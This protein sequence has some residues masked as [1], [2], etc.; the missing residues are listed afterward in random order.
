MG[1]GAYVYLP[2]SSL[3]PLA[4]TAA[5]SSILST[6]PSCPTNCVH[7]FP[8]SLSPFFFFLSSIYIAVSLSLFVHHHFVSPFFFVSI[9]RGESRETRPPPPAFLPSFVRIS[10]HQTYVSNEECM[11]TCKRCRLHLVLATSRRSVHA[12]ITSPH[13]SDAY[14]AT[15]DCG[16]CHDLDQTICSGRACALVKS[17]T[18]QNTDFVFPTIRTDFSFLYI[19]IYSFSLLFDRISEQ[20]EMKYSNIK[21]VVIFCLVNDKNFTIHRFVTRETS[22]TNNFVDYFE[23]NLQND[24]VQLTRFIRYNSRNEEKKKEKSQ[25]QSPPFSN[26]SNASHRA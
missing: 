20:A 6:Y 17:R 11:R 12:L 1:V 19:Y 22:R 8:L 14:Y 13:A 4:P 7:R 26:L 23:T 16:L 10:M 25:P 18:G 24:K 3:Q 2:L 5:V 15:A 9:L 21:F